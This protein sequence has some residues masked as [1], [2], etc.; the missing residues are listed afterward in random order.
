M[1]L[2]KRD[3]QMGDMMVRSIEELV[4]ELKLQQTKDG[5]TAA[6]VEQQRQHAAVIH[7][8]QVKQV[9]ITRTTNDKFQPPRTTRL[10][11]SSSLKHFE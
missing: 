11:N 3:P 6:G 4:Q 9:L 2:R 8:I 5:T 10:G 7:P 1:Q